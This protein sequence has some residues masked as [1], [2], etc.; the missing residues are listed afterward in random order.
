MVKVR[1][2]G[3]LQSATDDRAEVE[4]VA[5]IDELADLVEGAP[6]DETID[7]FDQPDALGDVDELVG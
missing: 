6:E 1:I 7:V 5:G 3:S 4:I 2:W